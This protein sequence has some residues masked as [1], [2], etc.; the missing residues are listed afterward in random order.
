MRP[1]GTLDD[2]ALLARLVA[3]DSTSDRS[4]LELADF[5]CD[6]VDR[7]GVRIARHPSPDG[8]KVNLVIAAGP[9]PDDRT[10]LVLSG[11][12][13]VVPAGDGWDSDPFTVV[14]RH[15]TYVGR[16][17]CDMKG[18]LALAVNR[19]AGTPADRLRHPLV[20]ILTYDEEVGTL[21]ARRLVETWPAGRR[22]PRAAII[23][24]PTSLAVVRLHKGHLRMRVEFAGIAAHSGLPHLGRNAIEPAGAAIVALTGLRKELEGER[25]AHSEEFPDVPFVSL[26]VARVA[27]GT[28][29][30]V[31]PE[32]CT[33]ELGIRL[34]PDVTSA[35]MANRVRTA[36]GRAVGDAPFVVTVLGESPPMAVPADAP[37]HRLL[38]GEVG[39]TVSRSASFASD[40]GWLRRLDLDCVLFGP[41]SM[42]VAHRPNEFLPIA[43][44]AHAADV[45]R[46]VVRRTCLE[47]AAA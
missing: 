37:I 36:I 31:V 41:G 24:E 21:G 6:Y 23:G 25:R 40:G 47:T 42:D 29:L 5:I 14:T 30:N 26:N 2:G 39:Q 32:S 38:C 1:S 27:G 28:A 13:D 10:G 20:L 11:H 44:F 46:T 16:G 18:F 34:L 9:E 12:L 45:L 19:L 35:E 33:L 8:R 22:L 17:T 4:N 15:G 43:E 7:P 3:F